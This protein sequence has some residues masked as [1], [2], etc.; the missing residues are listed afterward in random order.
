MG[1]GEY[2]K[3]CFIGNM[4]NSGYVMIRYLNDANIDTDLLL[5]EPGHAHFSPSA[6]T[7]NNQ[8]FDKVKYVGWNERNYFKVSSNEIKNELK[9]YDFII[10]T[11]YAPLYCSKAGI[12]LDIFIP[13][14]SDIFYTPF[15]RFS[16]SKDRYHYYRWLVSK[17]HRKAIENARAILFGKTNDENERLISKLDLKGQRIYRSVPLLYYPQYRDEL[18]LRFSETHPFSRLIG[19]IKSKFDVVLFHHCSH[20]WENQIYNLSYKANDKLIRGA[21]KFQRNNPSKKIALVMAEYGPDVAN[22]KQLIKKL[23]FEHNVFWFNKMNRKD[24]LTGLS[25]CDI[26][27]GELGHSWLTY[28]VVGEFMCFSK[29]IVHHR[30]DELYKTDFPELYPMYDASSE[31]DIEDMLQEYFGNKNAFIET[32][33]NANTWF[34]NY[35]INEPIEA[36]KSLINNK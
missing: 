16:F 24:L 33:K 36:I 15:I 31:E 7:Y 29:P 25:M 23:N 10:G 27:V 17:K 21:A 26:G 6:D 13:H 3:V 20:Q 11:D 4:N 19:E 12:V 32:G 34:S 1:K 5:M 14:G 28:G 35:I 30:K 18:F 2:M 22:S 9:Q 8:Y